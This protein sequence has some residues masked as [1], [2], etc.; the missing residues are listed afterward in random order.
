M[1][2]TNLLIDKFPSIILVILLVGL[3]ACKKKDLGPAEVSDNYVQEVKAWKQDRVESL[4]SPTGWLRLDGMFWLDEG[5]NSFGSGENQDIQFPESTIP[6]MAGTLTYENGRVLMNAA[7]DVPIMHE[8]EPVSEMVLYDGENQNTPH[9]EYGSLEWFVIVRED[10]VGIR[11]FNKD[12]EK[13]DQFT[14]FDSYPIDEKWNRRARFIPNPEGSAMSIVNVLGQQLDVASPGVLEFSID[15]KIYT[16]DAIDSDDDMFLIVGDQTNK[17][18]TYQAGRYI[19]VDFPEEGSQYTNIDF[20]KIY[21]P[22]C[23]FNVFTTCQLPPPQN[24]LDVAIKAGEKR[25]ENWQG[26]H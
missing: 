16:L 10:L 13:A 7:K 23:A 12:N 18:E 5:E 8:G 4:K 3:S 6:E 11:L 1:L 22:P 15:G 24:Q 20:N 14:G 9:V 19:Y 25:A 26:L 2:N 17:T 21:N